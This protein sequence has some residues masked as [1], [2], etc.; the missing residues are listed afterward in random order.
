MA[1]SF[2]LEHIFYNKKI[3]EKKKPTQINL[4]I[5]RIPFLP[6]NTAKLIK[7]AENKTGNNVCEKNI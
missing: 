5:K 7:L 1:L 2:K 3:R 4:L 6:F